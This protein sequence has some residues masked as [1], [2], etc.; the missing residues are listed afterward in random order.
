MLLASCSLLM[1]FKSS[2]VYATFTLRFHSCHNLL[3]IKEFLKVHEK[4]YSL[5]IPM[6]QSNK[7]FS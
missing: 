2:C 6:C 4:F 7:C 5:N 1:K 3:V